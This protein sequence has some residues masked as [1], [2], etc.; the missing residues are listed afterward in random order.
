MVTKKKQN[1]EGIIIR[2]VK[3]GENHKIFTIFTP[4]R[5]LLS[6]SAFGARKY[7]SKL[8]GNIE[9]LNWIEG[10][11]NYSAKSKKINIE[12]VSLKYSFINNLSYNIVWSVFPF[13]RFIN[14]LFFSNKEENFK[15]FKM[16][17]ALFQAL[18]K[19]NDE[20][21]TKLLLYSFVI[22]HLIM[23]SISQ[24]FRFCHIC[25]NDNQNI[26]NLDSFI[27]KDQCLIICNECFKR[28]KSAYKK[29]NKD[30]YN[31]LLEIIY[32][33]FEE[34]MNLTIKEENLH[35]IENF[36]NILL[37]NNFGKRWRD[38]EIEENPFNLESEV[39]KK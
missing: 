4:D 5:G 11:F 21:K 29:L 18:T 26:N 1:L 30:N 39:W 14:M 9:V 27:D 32:S 22:K 19:S 25:G 3:Y 38:F 15:I 8:R 12:E 6:A 34:I 7:K 37:Y 28:E 35:F 2:T 31:L 36:L 17:I 13:L 23:T 20:N 24:N 16:L 10:L 33:K